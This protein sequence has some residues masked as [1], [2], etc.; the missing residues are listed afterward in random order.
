MQLKSRYILIVNLV[1]LVTMT[2]FFV[3]DDY[4]MQGSHLEAVQRGTTD[5]VLARPI[6]ERIRDD[7]QSLISPDKQIEQLRMELRTMRDL[8]E[9][10]DVLEVRLTLSI[11]QPKV[12]ASLTGESEGTFLTLSQQDWAIL[13][14]YTQSSQGETAR[15]VAGMQRYRGKWATRLVTP[16]TWWA[17]VAIPD[18]QQSDAP[19]YYLAA[20]LIEVLLDSSEV[21]SYWQSFRLIH[22][23]YVLVFALT[24]TVFVDM[25]TNR[26]VLRPLERLA[27]I[28]R[29]GEEGEVDT[30]A[31]FPTNEV[32]RISETLTQMLATMKRL[33]DE[34]VT[35]LK[36]LANGVAHEIRNPL[37]SISI[38]V[39]YLRE[40]LESDKLSADQRADAQEML[41]I[42]LQQVTE[43]NRITT[44]FLNLTR[45]ARLELEAV[46]LHDLLERLVSEVAPQAKEAGVQVSCDFDPA[47]GD[48]WLD[49]D[50]FR[51]AIYNLVQ[52]ALQAMPTSGSLFLSTRTRA[53][54]VVVEVRD[55]GKGMAPEIQERIFD[56][57]FTTR[58]QEGG[59]GL[60]LTL[61]Q[62][63]IFAHEGTIQVRSQP[64]VGTAF[65]ISLPMM[66][67]G[68]RAEGA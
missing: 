11:E 38:S 8:P 40:L 67:S 10:R 7:V 68:Q 41:Q 48:I 57:Y 39:Q 23:L 21:A 47:V 59:L 49:V 37:N 65:T 12:I 33:H 25:A 5:G 26:M 60:G 30:R 29:R 61:A 4:R 44:Q 54:H 9:M 27:D 20:G 3:L 13:T 62:S 51:S 56:P 22:L 34:R 58:E 53:R 64:G 45:P 43:L 6:L 28:V 15:I 55:T 66:P 16:Y 24:V 50:Q 35:N 46:S 32:G 17:E 14:Q 2:I 36:R 18:G 1:I 42:V 19:E 63:A 52:N 31:I